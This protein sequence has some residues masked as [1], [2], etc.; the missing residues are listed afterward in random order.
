MLLFF[1]EP[2]DD[3]E[4]SLWSCCC[5]LLEWEDDLSLF[6]V[7][8]LLINRN[9]SLSAGL[10]VD[11]GIGCCGVDDDVIAIIVVVECGAIKWSE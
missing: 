8:V 4:E 10:V 5:C 11:V 3:D 1:Y 6:A 2:R 9:S 7:H